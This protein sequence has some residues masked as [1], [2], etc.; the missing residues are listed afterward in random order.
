MK[1]LNL[2]EFLEDLSWSDN[3][4]HKLR[5]VAD[6]DDLYALSAT[7]VEGKLTAQAWTKWPDEWPENTVA[8][9]CKRSMSKSKTMQA[10]DLVLDTGMSVYSA[11]KQIGVNPS[12][13][14]RAIARRDNRAICSCCGQVIR[15]I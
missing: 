13:V 15:K 9:W 12:A 2:A 1:K 5:I 7:D 3:V 11:A 6:R 14:H 8:V 4:R 10:V